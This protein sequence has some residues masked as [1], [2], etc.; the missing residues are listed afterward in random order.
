LP[1]TERQ[2]AD[3]PIFAA[4]ESRVCPNPLS[5]LRPPALALAKIDEAE[6]TRRKLGHDVVEEALALVEVDE[7]HLRADDRDAVQKALRAAQNLKLGSLCI[8]L[9]E[10]D[11][12]DL[13]FDGK[14][15]K[16]HA[17]DLALGD[18]IECA[19]VFI[20]LRH[21]DIR[22][23]QR[24][25]GRLARYVQTMTP[26]DT[27]KADIVAIKFRKS[28][29]VRDRRVFARLDRMHVAKSANGT[30]IK[31]RTRRADVDQRQP[32]CQNSG[33]K[34]AEIAHIFPAGTLSS[35]RSTLP[36]FYFYGNLPYN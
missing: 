21:R 20:P 13:V 8:E 17:F 19:V 10:V 36:R 35:H 34:V 7:F 26:P 2:S 28:M 24:A 14:I 31:R 25:C 18:D 27:R 32:A 11:V 3:R 23:T 12:R 4:H 16:R 6:P 30:D 1:A 29:L 9:D 5:G 33:T 15:G 22:P